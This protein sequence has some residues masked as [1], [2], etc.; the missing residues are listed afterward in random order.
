MINNTNYTKEELQVIKTALT[1]LYGTIS[2]K[3]KN[4]TCTTQFQDKK[5]GI[6]ENMKIDVSFFNAQNN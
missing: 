1:M 5:T 4:F 2:D 3:S 6:S